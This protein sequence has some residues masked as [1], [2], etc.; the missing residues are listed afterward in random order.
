MIIIR[1]FMTYKPFKFFAIPGVISF[2]LGF[3]IGLRFSYFYLTVG[4]SGHIQSL[5]L[6]ALLM[7]IGFFLSVIGLIADLISVNRKLLEKI[8]WRV[9]KIEEIHYQKDIKAS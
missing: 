8:D 9:Q 6:A 2:V 4:S 3:L 1:I 5:I 7:G